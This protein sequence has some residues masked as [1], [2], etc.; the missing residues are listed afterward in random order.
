MAN[1]HEAMLQ[2]RRNNSDNLGIIVHIFHKN[3]FCDPSL[4][5]DND[6]DYQSCS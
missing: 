6:H 2:I 3:I 4:E 5:H 1:V